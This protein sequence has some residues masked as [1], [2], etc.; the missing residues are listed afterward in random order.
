MEFFERLISYQ[1]RP[2]SRY[3]GMAFAAIAEFDALLDYIF[4]TPRFLQAEEALE[5]KKLDA[6]FPSSDMSERN[7]F[8]RRARAGSEFGKIFFKFP[9][10]LTTSNLLIATS[11][12]EHHLV[13]LVEE[14]SRQLGVE[15]GAHVGVAKAI[16]NI[17][18]WVPEFKNNMLLE[19]V[20]SAIKIRNRLVHDGGRLTNTARCDEVRSIVLRK[21]H[22]SAFHR[23]RWV[24]QGFGD[25]MVFIASLNGCDWIRMDKDYAFHATAYFRDFYLSA[26]MALDPVDPP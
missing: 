14:H 25:E 15:V 23:Q 7:Q 4:K 19:P 9:V 8:S 10:F 22:I 13:Q 1:N 18:A 24:E 11:L 2:S 3:R 16:R 12:L 21:T 6:Y 17:S 20:D 5:R 26:C